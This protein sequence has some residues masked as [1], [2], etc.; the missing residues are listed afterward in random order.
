MPRVD[1]LSHDA[2]TMADSV[3]V[4]ATRTGAAVRMGSAA[5]PY[6]GPLEFGGWPDGREFV[7][8]GRY[9]FPAAKRLA[10]DVASL[11]SDALQRGLDAFPW[12]N[13]TTNAEAVHD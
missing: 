13:I 11:Y 7:S 5:L 12:S 9:L 6:A 4:S 3:R 1:T 8:N 10:T 2:G